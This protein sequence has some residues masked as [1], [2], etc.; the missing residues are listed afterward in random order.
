M[1]E[2]IPSITRRMYMLKYGVRS[3]VIWNECQ[4]KKIGVISAKAEILDARSKQQIR[5]TRRIDYK[6]TAIKSWLLGTTA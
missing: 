1:V 4:H 2:I 6:Y 5:C 3:L